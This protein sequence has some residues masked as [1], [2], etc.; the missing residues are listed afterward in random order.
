M[1]SICYINRNP[2]TWNMYYS[3]KKLKEKYGGDTLVHITYG[4]FDDYPQMF[5]LEMLMRE[6]I[7]NRLISGEYRVSEDSHWKRKLIVVNKDGE[8]IE[9]IDSEICY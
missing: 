9:P 8:V 6:K 1:G 4:S 7:Y 5:D 2:K 3:D